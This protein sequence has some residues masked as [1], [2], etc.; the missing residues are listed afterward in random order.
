MFIKT[1][2]HRLGVRGEVIQLG[3]VLVALL[4]VCMGIPLWNLAAPGGAMT[5]FDQW[6]MGPVVN[7]VLVIVGVNFRGWARVLSAVFLPSMVHVFNFLVFGIGTTFSLSMIPAIW[8]GNLAMVLTYKYFYSHKKV[9]FWFV[10]VMAV[11]FKVAII[12]SIFAIL[13]WGFNYFPPPVLEGMTPRMTIN[14]VYVAAIG[15]VVGWLI[16]RFV[17]P[18]GSAKIV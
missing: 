1:Y 18:R 5:N 15:V 6:I 13:A 14:Q 3:G 8:L 17:Y 11:T 12:A 2:R 9:N 10:S 7:T 16:L 4:L